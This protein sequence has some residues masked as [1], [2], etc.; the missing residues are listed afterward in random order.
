V[1]ESV[2]HGTHRRTW[3]SHPNH[4]GVLLKHKVDVKGEELRTWELMC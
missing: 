3:M 1:E 2:G 4:L